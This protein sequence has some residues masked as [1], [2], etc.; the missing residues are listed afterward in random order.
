M[1]L[2]PLS[3]LTS[4]VSL[5]LAEAVSR[6]SGFIGLDGVKVVYGKVADATVFVDS[7]ALATAITNLLSNAFRFAKNSIE[8]S[9]VQR[10]GSVVISVADDGPGIA[11]EDLEHIFDRFYKG[12]QGKYGLGLSI[13]SAIS[14]GHDGVARAYNRNGKDGETGAVFEIILPVAKKTNK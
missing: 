1:A 2:L 4:S 14:V 8:L 10:D 3:F 6:V 5:I 11:A 12:R 13:V 9:A 7:D